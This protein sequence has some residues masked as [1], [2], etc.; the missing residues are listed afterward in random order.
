MA[1]DTANP[2]NVPFGYCHCGCGQKTTIIKATHSRR[3]RIKG[4]PNKFLPSHHVCQEPYVSTEPFIDGDTV[5]I[6]LMTGLR[7]RPVA[8]V[9][10]SDFEAVMQYRWAHM[11]RPNGAAKVCAQMDGKW[12]PLHRYLTNTRSKKVVDHAD[13]DPLNNH[14]S[15]LRPCTSSDNQLNTYKIRRGKPDSRFKG[16]ARYGIKWRSRLTF[17]GQEFTS[18]PFDSEETAARAY[19]DFLRDVNPEFGRFNFPRDGERSALRPESEATR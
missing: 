19:D 5:V 3:G 15:N 18:Q 1:D 14:R 13:G 6:P 4:Q 7:P 16:V 10:A 9:D 12:V 11:P 17:K 2:L 8:L